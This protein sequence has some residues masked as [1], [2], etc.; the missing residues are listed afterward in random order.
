VNTPASPRPPIS[1][2]IPIVVGIAIF[3]V[4][5]VS[6]ALI[7]FILPET[8]VSV[9]RVTIATSA[10]TNQAQTQ[11]NVA[12]SAEVNRISSPAV[13]GKAAAALDLK[14]KWGRR[15]GV[16]DNLGDAEVSAL[17]RQRIDIAP[18]RNSPSL[19]IRVFDE[20]PRDAADL[21]NA[22]AES[23]C[24]SAPGSRILEKASPGLRPVRPNKPL[25]LA[26]GVAAGLLLGGIVAGLLLLLQRS[27][28]RLRLT[29][30]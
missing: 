16:G 20:S 22:I 28:S 13:L 5:V 1:V 6:A 10:N 4:V 23:Y 9:A 30:P 2:A 8:Y 25:N 14:S 24:A 29:A 26:L 15:Y 21:A 7:T 17:L 18:V 3:F 27:S 11:T 19:D 12:G